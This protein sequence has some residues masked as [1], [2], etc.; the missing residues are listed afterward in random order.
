[1]TQE[2]KF[3]R[4]IIIRLAKLQSDLNY[5]KEKM[6]FLENN[7]FKSEMAIWEEASVG[8]NADF[9]EKHNL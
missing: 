1:M 4:E 3:N 9:F 5:I 6:E 8:D 2:I 7:A